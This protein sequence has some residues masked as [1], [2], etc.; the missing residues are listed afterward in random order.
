M[1]LRWRFAI[2]L[3]FVVR[4]GGEPLGRFPHLRLES[5]GLDRAPRRIVESTFEQLNSVGR[6]DVLLYF[7]CP[8]TRQMRCPVNDYRFSYQGL[9]ISERS[10][11]NSGLARNRFLALEIN[12]STCSSVMLNEVGIL[13][14]NSFNFSCGVSSKLTCMK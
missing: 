1:F 7:K 13:F 3:L 6:A 11:W 5:A 2:A 12:E 9:A 4:L 14:R 8:T 10:R